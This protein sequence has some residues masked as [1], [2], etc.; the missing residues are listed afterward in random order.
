M[1]GSSGEFSDSRIY[2]M[3]IPFE[4]LLWVGSKTYKPAVGK[5]KEGDQTW[6]PD[7]NVGC[8]TLVV[9]TGVSESLPRL[10]QDA[11]R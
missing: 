4:E 3:N 10:R 5:S 9:E 7:E 1:L 8:P 11:K 2:A 6:L